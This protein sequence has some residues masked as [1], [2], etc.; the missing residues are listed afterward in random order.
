VVGLGHLDEGREARMCAAW[1]ASA[2]ATCSSRYDCQSQAP[3]AM[4]VGRAAAH[5]GSI[6]GLAATSCQYATQ[7]PSMRPAGSRP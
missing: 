5:R 2:R 7:R 4:R 6:V 1:R 3:Q